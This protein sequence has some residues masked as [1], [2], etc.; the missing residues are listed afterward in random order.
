MR[1]FLT[2]NFGIKGLL[3]IKYS[4]RLLYELPGNFQYYHSKTCYNCIVYDDDHDEELF[5]WY[6]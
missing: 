2:T 1:L 4:Q 5:L 3:T 6:G